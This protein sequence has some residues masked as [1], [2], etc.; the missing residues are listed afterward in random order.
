MVHKIMNIVHLNTYD[1]AGGA[2]RAAY[3]LHYSLLSLNQNSLMVVQKKDS[4]DET[5][6]EIGS[7]N[8]VNNPYFS[9][10]NYIQKHYLNNNRTSLTNTLFSLNYFGWDVTN[11]SVIKNADVIN[12]HWVA[13]GFQSPATIEKILNLGKPVV[14]TLHDMNPFTGGC[15]YSNYCEEYQH[16]CESC[17]QL[18]DDLYSLPY[19]VLGDKLQLINSPNLTIVS[20]SRW[21]ADC[22]KK[23]SLFSAREVKFI[24]YGIS[25]SFINSTEKSKVKESLNISKDSLVLL[26]GAVNGNEERKGFRQLI[27]VLKICLNDSFFANLIQNHTLKIA[28]FGEPHQDLFSLPFEVISFGTVKCDRTLSNI[29]RAG[30]IFVLPSLEDNLPN[31]IVESMACGTPVIGFNIG[32]LPDVVIEGKTGYLAEKNNLTMMAEKIINLLKSES[33]R[34]TISEKCQRMIQENYLLKHQGESYTKLYQELLLKNNQI[35]P[36]L[37]SI[38]IEDDQV[39]FNQDIGDCFKAIY[40]KVSILSHRKEIEELNNKNDHKDKDIQNLY[41]IIDNQNSHIEKINKL[42]QEKES[43]LREL[44][45]QQKELRETI[46]KKDKYYQELLRETIDKKDKHY[47]ELL[48]KLNLTQLKIEEIETSKFWLLRNQW[49]SLKNKIAN[50]SN[51]F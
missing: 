45:T 35:K 23:S 48:K 43:K 12:L 2:A 7:T 4:D 31:T 41:E 25:S 30:D 20:P 50:F 1:I 18:K 24:P 42:L 26:V 15:H 16:R 49:L 40:E 6:I 10:A 9:S 13:N 34:L 39:S 32:G 17:P 37:S 47:Q 8:L 38:D 44:Y 28:C 11:L 14:W 3:R 19:H 5:V 29:Y 36:R 33:L 46:D 27:E 21:L 51:L 22:A